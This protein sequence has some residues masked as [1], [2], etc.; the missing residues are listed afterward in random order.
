MPALPGRRM[1]RCQGSWTCS[2]ASLRIAGQARAVLEALSSLAARL[3]TSD[4]Q[5]SARRL[6]QQLR[7]SRFALPYLDCLSAT[8]GLLAANGSFILRFAA[9]TQTGDPSSSAICPLCSPPSRAEARV[10]EESASPHCDPE[11]SRSRRSSG[12]QCGSARAS[13]GSFRSRIRP[14]TPCHAGTSPQTS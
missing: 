9:K 5:A 14:A 4:R 10:P 8:R 7:A 13:F 6:R 11:R 1:L 12:F 3:R 2:L